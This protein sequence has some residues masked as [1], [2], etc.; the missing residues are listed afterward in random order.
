MTI[1]TPGTPLS[2]RTPAFNALWAMSEWALARIAEHLGASPEPH[3]NRARALTSALQETFDDELGVYLPRDVR[4]GEFLRYAGISGIIPLVLPESPL[5]AR[6][7]QTLRGPRFGLGRVVMVP[8]H[9]LTAP[10][11][12]GARYWR[13][14]SWF[15]TAWLVVQGLHQAGAHREAEILAAHAVGQAVAGDYPEYVDPLT[16]SAHGTRL[17]SWTAALALDLAVTQADQRSRLP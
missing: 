2:S 3:R 16:G 9:D 6:I 10:E 12:D 4:T 13:G 15:N 11:Y 1:R 14:P 7:L 5:Q 8:S 17:F